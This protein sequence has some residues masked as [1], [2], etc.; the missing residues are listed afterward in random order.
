MKIS[1]PYWM[2]IMLR[3]TEWLE[4]KNI[5]YTIFGSACFSLLVRPISTKDIDILIRPFPEI[6]ESSKFAIELRSLLGGVRAF[7][8]FDALEGDRIIVEVET[9]DGLVGIE[10]WSH[11]LREKKSVIFID[12]SIEVQYHGS[13]LRILPP[14]LF[15]ATKLCELTPEPADKEKIDELLHVYGEKIDIE[16]VIWAIKILNCSSLARGNIDLWYEEKK[17]KILMEILGQI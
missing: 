11:I 9:P 2:S 14:E 10:L 1:P 4:D 17:P 5:S 13:T 8:L 12:K 15:L 16:Y 3:A 6:E 7:P